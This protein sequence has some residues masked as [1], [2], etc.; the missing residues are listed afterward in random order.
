MLDLQNMDV[1]EEEQIGQSGL[2]D[3]MEED[4]SHY[5]LDGDGRGSFRRGLEEEV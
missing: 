4:I 3:T 5:L 2:G 1:L